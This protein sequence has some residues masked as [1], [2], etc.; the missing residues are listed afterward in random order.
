GWGPAHLELRVT[1]RG[2]RIIE[3]NPRLA[4]GFIPRLVRLSLGV[5]LIEQTIR[6]VSGQ[7]PVLERSLA[8]HASIRFLLPSEDG[9]FVGADGIDEAKNLPNVIE[10]NVYAQ[11]ESKVERRGD[12]RDRIGHVIACGPE[13]HS[14]RCAAETA[15]AAIRLRVRPR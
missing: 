14:V 13:A 9:V 11:P 8:R 2:I 15:H 10:V 4:G 6:L 7:V 1:N 5:D 12:F 3:V